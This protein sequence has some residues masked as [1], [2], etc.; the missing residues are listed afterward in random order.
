MHPGTRILVLG[1]AAPLSGSELPLHLRGHGPGIEWRIGA[2]RVGGFPFT[3]LDVVMTEVGHV[4]AAIRGAREGADAIL[5]DT[6][7]EYGIAAMRSAL[8]IPVVGAAEAAVAEARAIGPRF[9]I[10]TVWPASM[11]W[12]Y[13]RQAALLGVRDRCVGVRYVGGGTT[14]R[15]SPGSTLDAMHRSDT[16]WLE[17]IGLACDEIAKLGASSIVLGCTCMAPLSKAIA[18]R[19]PIPVI[20]A[21]HA[22]ARAVVREIARRAGARVPGEA[23]ATLKS[24]MAFVSWVDGMAPTEAGAGAACPVCIT[25]A[26]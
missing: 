3:P 1:T 6:Y 26:D 19:S 8:A 25:S 20:C 22:G 21:A 17:R 18:E 7:G 11:D 4:D 9:G 12:L 10:V 24:T 13:E 14:D 2:T 16:G 15:A 23:P 5:L